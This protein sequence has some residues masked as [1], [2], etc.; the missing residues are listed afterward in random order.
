[1]IVWERLEIVLET[2]STLASLCMYTWDLKY[3]LD[4]SCL[5]NRKNTIGAIYVLHLD[6]LIVFLNFSVFSITSA[7]F[8]ILYT[9]QHDAVICTF[10]YTAYLKI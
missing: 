3:G 2:I 9:T 1:M 4:S 8:Y 6:L 5:V 7:S 10:Q